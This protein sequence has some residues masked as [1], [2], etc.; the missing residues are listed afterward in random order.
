MLVRSNGGR[1]FDG[2]A[3]KKEPP[4]NNLAELVM[5]E[6]DF[7]KE[8][9]EQQGAQIGAAQASGRRWLRLA[10]VALLACPGSFVG[11]VMLAAE[12]AQWAARVFA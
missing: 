1:Y 12:A 10:V 9:A 5:K 11:G 4:H 3:V 2:T 6:R 8:K 7:W